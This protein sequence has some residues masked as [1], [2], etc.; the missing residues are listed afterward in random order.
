MKIKSPGMVKIL[1]RQKIEQ[2]GFNKSTEFLKL[3][4]DIPFLFLMQ[5]LSE[6]FWKVYRARPGR[7]LML[8]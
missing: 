7:N 3:L 6:G 5:L 1:I 4:T 8:L 2:Y